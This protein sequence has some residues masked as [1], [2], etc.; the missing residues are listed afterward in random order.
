MRQRGVANIVVG[1]VIAVDALIMSKLLDVLSLL[2]ELFGIQ[3]RDAPQH[4]EGRLCDTLRRPRVELKRTMNDL[5]FAGLA[6]LAHGLVE[7]MGA[8]SAPRADDVRPNLDLHL[9]DP[10]GSAIAMAGVAG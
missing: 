7:S 8:K 10:F 5:R 1:H 2:S 6:G 4:S 3:P 9:G